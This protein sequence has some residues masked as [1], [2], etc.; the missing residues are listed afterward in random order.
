MATATKKSELRLLGEIDKKVKSL[1]PEGLKTL[2]LVLAE[3]VPWEDIGTVQG[4]VQRYADLTG[5]G[6][7]YVLLTLGVE[8]PEET[9]EASDDA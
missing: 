3:S 2:H 7:S 4:I 5:T 9:G 8:M 1:S 6:K